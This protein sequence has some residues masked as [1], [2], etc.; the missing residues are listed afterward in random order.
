[1]STAGRVDVTEVSCVPMYSNIC[2]E[3]TKSCEE[4]S[5]DKI[6]SRSKFWV[7]DNV[8]WEMEPQENFRTLGT[9]S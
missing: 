5:I 7:G 4:M 9:L 1:M 3:T 6:L 8:I 2:T